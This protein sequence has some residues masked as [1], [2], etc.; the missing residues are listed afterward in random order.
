M[1]IQHGEQSKVEKRYTWTFTMRRGGRFPE[2]LTEGS[3][4]KRAI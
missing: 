2:E 3:S 4:T 1:F